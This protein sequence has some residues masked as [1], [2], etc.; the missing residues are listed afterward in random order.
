MSTKAK[1]EGW[2]SLLEELEGASM[3]VEVFKPETA[4]MSIPL[5]TFIFEDN[6]G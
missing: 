2:Y 5:K 6:W 4:I 1:V 3:H